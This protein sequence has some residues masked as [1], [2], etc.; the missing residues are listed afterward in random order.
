MNHEELEGLVPL[1]ALDALGPA[2]EAEIRAHVAGCESC[3]A[4]LGEHLETAAGLALMDGPA[5]PPAHLRARL[6]AGIAE[7]PEAAVT[8][9]PPSPAPAAA[10]AASLPGPGAGPDPQARDEVDARRRAKADAGRHDGADRAD[11]S[12]RSDRSWWQRFGAVVAVAACVVL[13]L[14][15]YAYDS[16][17]D[18]AARLDAVAARQEQIRQLVDGRQPSMSMIPTG[19]GPASGGLV[20]ARGDSAAV[21]LDGLDADA[22]GV[23][24]VWAIRGG[25]P[26]PVA[27]VGDDDWQGPAGQAVVLLDGGVEG[28]EGMAVSIEPSEPPAGAQGPKGPIV[29]ST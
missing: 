18:N 15:W 10:A 21:V 29:L 27:A 13:G 23:Y 4:L 7:E 25:K 3:A 9:A 20:F 26:V 1:L 12:D 19:N 2:E 5:T 11:R 6:M 8:S 14:T 16:V 24:E 28:V 22:E 17:S